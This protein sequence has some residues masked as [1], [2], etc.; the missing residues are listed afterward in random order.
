MNIS[1]LFHAQQF[2][3]ERDKNVTFKSHESNQG[4]HAMELTTIFQR[5]VLFFAI[6]DVITPQT[7]IKTLFLSSKNR[8][9]Q[10][11]GKGLIYFYN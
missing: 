3:K 6:N 9:L 2:G 7:K 4:H 1:L 5:I 11:Y 10:K 8:I